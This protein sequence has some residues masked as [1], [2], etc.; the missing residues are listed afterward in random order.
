[1]SATLL[2]NIY[3]TALYPLIACFILTID[4]L[5][6]VYDNHDNDNDKNDSDNNDSDSNDSNDNDNDND[7][8]SND[9]N[10]NNNYCLRTCTLSSE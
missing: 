2:M 7:N 5:S 10:D 1:M 3:F 9:N 4:D 6:T 8:D